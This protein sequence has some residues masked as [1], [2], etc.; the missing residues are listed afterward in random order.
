M[1]HPG[2][3]AAHG[4]QSSRAAV[5][6]VLP[7]DSLRLRTTCPRFSAATRLAIA[8][9]SGFLLLVAASGVRGQSEDGAQR[10]PNDSAIGAAPAKA[11]SARPPLKK[12]GT[13][14]NKK[15][16]PTSSDASRATPVARKSVTCEAL[17]GSPNPE[18]LSVWRDCEDTPEMVT[19]PGGSFLMGEL[20]ETGLL[21]ERPIREVQIR[22]FAI[23]RFEATFV[24]WDLCEGDGF[25]QVH[26]DDKGW[27]R[28]F[29]P[30]INVSW[31]D[32]QQYVAW[33]SRRTGQRYRLA[34]EAEWEYAAR[35]GTTTSF[36]W[37]ESMSAT[38]DNANSFDIAGHNARPNWFWSV[39][40]ADGY[41]YTA[42]VGSFPPNPWGLYDMQGNVWEWVQDCW[43][44]D[45]TGAPT[46]GSAWIEDG[47]CNK[48][49][50][51]GGGWGNHPRTLRSAKR[52]ADIATGYGDAFGFRVVRELPQPVLP[53]LPAP[54]PRVAPAPQTTPRA[55]A[56]SPVP[57]PD[58][59]PVFTPEGMV[60]PMPSPT[61]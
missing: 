46:D 56:E 36:P 43:H 49:V 18:P 9:A 15:G 51:R 60:E 13:P 14:R 31:V 16:A 24:D 61:P 29:H 30:V 59:Q 10:A 34:T 26:P 57:S 53:D 41:T 32:A 42:P 5:R 55:P 12:K 25:C 27:G 17:P 48:R 45:Y 33:L 39:F 54:G 28:G 50:N 19:M 35:A 52:D 58:V 47:D 40:C 22:P 38:C 44:S 20:G 21:Y 7:F 11:P 8:L 4:N 6:S 2:L 23:S 3:P 37:G 1:Q